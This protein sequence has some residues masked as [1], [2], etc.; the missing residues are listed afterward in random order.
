MFWFCVYGCVRIIGDSFSSILKDPGTTGNF[1]VTA[2]GTG[3]LLHSRKT[4]GQGKCESTEERAALIQKIKQLFVK[5]G[6][7]IPQRNAAAADQAISEKPGGCII[8]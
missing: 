2:V 1:E 3:E 4:M 6:V 8:L 5:A 7:S